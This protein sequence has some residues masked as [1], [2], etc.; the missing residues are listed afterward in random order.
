MMMN[1]DGSEGDNGDNSEV[2]SSLKIVNTVTERPR[3]VVE[4]GFQLIL[5][6]NQ[7]QTCDFE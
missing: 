3:E 4:F 1:D 7:F 5:I 2:Q 6:L